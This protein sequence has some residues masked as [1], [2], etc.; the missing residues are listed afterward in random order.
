M[1]DSSG[2]LEYLSEGP[3]TAMWGNCYSGVE[4]QTMA[5]C[6]SQSPKVNTHK[7]TGAAFTSQAVVTPRQRCIGSIY[8]LGMP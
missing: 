3:N 6:V 8:R 2:W 1:V 4:I 7:F 5:R